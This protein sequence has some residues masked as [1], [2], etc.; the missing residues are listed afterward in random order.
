MSTE[1]KQS[2]ADE[3]QT[4]TSGSSLVACSSISKADKWIDL[5]VEVLELWEASSSA[6]AQVGLLGDSSGVVKFVSWEKSNLSQLKEGAAYSLETVV[7]DEYDRRF[8][9][10]LNAK[11]SIEEITGPEAERERL[12]ADVADA[13]ALETIDTPDQWLDVI[14]EVDQLWEPDVESMAQ[15]GLLA[16]STGRIKFVSWKKSDLPEL[17]EG[18]S[19]KLSNVVTDEYDDRFSIK[20]NSETEIEHLG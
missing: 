11:T 2:T 19:Y 9:V 7:T 20:L 3:A 5:E 8:S 17:E 1:S 10:N 15:V 13:V 6:V 12:A 16:D 14:V 18:A 4:M